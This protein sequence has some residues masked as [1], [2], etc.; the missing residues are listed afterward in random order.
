MWTGARVCATVAAIARTGVAMPIRVDAYTAGGMA[1]GLL[2]R[3]GH[4]RD[5]LETS[6]QLPLERV[7]W[8]ALGETRAS[9]VGD[10]TIP[11][12][13]VLIAMTDEEPSAAVHASWHRVRLELGPYVVDGELP[14]LPGYDP[15]R[16]LARPSGEFVLLRDVHL[17][18]AP[19]EADQGVAV[20]FA[21]VNR[22]G[23]ER[24]LADIMLGFFF[25]GAALDGL[26]EASDAP[27]PAVPAAG[28]A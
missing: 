15:G 19:S 6:Q 20:P 13:D 3:S 24:V 14:T 28:P 1:S 27:V 10:V 22:Y 17:T 18:P 23:T 12:D 25:P 16:A 11:V 2:A 7:A 4:L 21:F 5:A 8:H 26:E 9:P